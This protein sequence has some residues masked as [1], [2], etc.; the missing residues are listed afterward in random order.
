MVIIIDTLKSLKCHSDCPCR[1]FSSEKTSRLMWKRAQRQKHFYAS[2][3]RRK[4]QA[5]P[6]Q[7]LAKFKRL[8]GHSDGLISLNHT[9]S[10]ATYRGVARSADDSATKLAS[11][12]SLEE[13]SAREHSLYQ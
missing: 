10:P 9:P 4:R 1:G 5:N 3:G 13:L 6:A 2:A 11:S 8:Q 7:R 12:S